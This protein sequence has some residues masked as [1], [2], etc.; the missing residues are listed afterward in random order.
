LSTLHT[1]NPEALLLGSDMSPAGMLL[2][3]STPDLAFLCIVNGIEFSRL[4]TREFLVS[5]VGTTM[6]LTVAAAPGPGTPL[7]AVQERD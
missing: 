4:W 2:S 5:V 6:A 7:W 3:G 1:S